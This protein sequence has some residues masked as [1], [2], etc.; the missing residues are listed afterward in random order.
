[1][2]PM[3]SRK[4]QGILSMIKKLTIQE[5]TELSEKLQEDPNWPGATMSPVGANPKPRPPTLST[6]ARRGRSA[7]NEKSTR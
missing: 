2:S 4:V 1:M 5:L 3:A 6:T 7:T